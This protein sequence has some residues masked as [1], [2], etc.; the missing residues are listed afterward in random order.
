LDI[1][2]STTLYPPAVLTLG[3]V[4]GVTSGARELQDLQEGYDQDLCLLCFCDLTRPDGW[5][6]RTMLGEW[7]SQK[8]GEDVPA[9]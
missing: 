3:L 7:I 4:A 2:R 1:L 5:C 8:T 9:R 6:H